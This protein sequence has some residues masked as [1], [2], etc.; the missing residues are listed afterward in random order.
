MILK[1]YYLLIYNLLMFIGWSYF[2]INLNKNIFIY[3]NSIKDIYNNTFYLLK[4]VQYGMTLEILHSIIKFVKSPILTV[5][6]QVLTRNLIVLILQFFPS[7]ISFGYLLLSL[8]WSSI[9]IVRYPFYVFSILK[10]DLN[11]KI[12]IPYFLIWCRYS[13]FIVLYPI[14]VSGEMIT[15]LYSR[16]DLDKYSNYFNQ[17][18]LSYIIYIFYLLYIPGLFVMYKYL[19]KQRKKVLGKIN[20]KESLKKE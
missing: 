20:N 11:F 17:I 4:I 3:K 8:A 15:L 1:S 19:L 10:K 5:C 6:M 12:E 9:E 7:S 16:E 2:L 18:K 14:G 13:F